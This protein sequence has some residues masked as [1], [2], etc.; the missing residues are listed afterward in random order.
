MLSVVKRSVFDLHISNTGGCNVIV[1]M[2]FITLNVEVGLVLLH[3]GFISVIKTL[4]CRLLQ[5]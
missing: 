5:Q 3:H 1:L 2:L 4:T